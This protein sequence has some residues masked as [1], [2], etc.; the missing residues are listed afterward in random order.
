MVGAERQRSR[1]FR[2][3][4]AV[5]RQVVAAFVAN[6]PGVG[7]VVAHCLPFVAWALPWRPLFVSLMWGGRRQSAGLSPHWNIRRTGRAVIVAR[8][9][10]AGDQVLGDLGRLLAGSTRC[11]STSGR[12]D[13]GDQ[14]LGDLGRLGPAP[15]SATRRS[16]SLAG[17]PQRSEGAAAPEAPGCDRGAGD[18]GRQPS[19]P[20]QPLAGSNLSR[21]ACLAV[22]ARFRCRQGGERLFG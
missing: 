17:N 15:S 13:L 11:S 6:A 5:V 21:S 20:A 10:V 19:A 12:L 18:R 22:L 16:S 3:A 8:V 9:I 2:A 1:G 7:A 4:V 14:V